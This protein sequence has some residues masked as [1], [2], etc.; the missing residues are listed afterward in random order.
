MDTT[1]GRVKARCYGLLDRTVRWALW[2][3]LSGMSLLVYV[4]LEVNAP[5]MWCGLGHV[6]YDTITNY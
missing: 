1:P 6:R 4:S 3:G 5:V 2:A